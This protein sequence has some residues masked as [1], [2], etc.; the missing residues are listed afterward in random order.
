LVKW[1]DEN[2][3]EDP[4]APMEA[5]GMTEEEA[6]QEGP[7]LP[8]G[9][10]LVLWYERCFGPYTGDRYYIYS[11]VWLYHAKND[12]SSSYSW[13]IDVQKAWFHGWDDSDYKISQAFGGFAWSRGQPDGWY[14][15]A[16]QN[17]ICDPN[18][19]TVHISVPLGGGATAS[20][21]IPVIRCWTK[22]YG[23]ANTETSVFLVWQGATGNEDDIRRY[24]YWASNRR[25]QGA[26]T[27][28]KTT[29]WPY[30]SLA[31]SCKS[32]F[33]C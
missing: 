13:D 31:F 5:I 7:T 26:P 30:P 1:F 27:E 4:L 15:D 11:C 9:S 12:G 8:P 2:E 33:G 23:Y 28:F 21:S 10:H 17:H 18:P 32:P 16:T 29:I 19:W 24:V 20:A 14:P 22:L 25:A 3:V 6:T